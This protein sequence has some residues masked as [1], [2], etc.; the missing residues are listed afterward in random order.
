MKLTEALFRIANE[1]LKDPELSKD[2][3]EAQTKTEQA[4]EF[5]GFWIE[6]LKLP[7]LDKELDPY[8][9]NTQDEAA[10]STLLEAVT[11]YEKIPELRADKIRYKLR[12]EKVEAELEKVK[13]DVKQSKTSQDGLRALLDAAEEILVIKQKQVEEA[14]AELARWKPL[15]EWA[16][17]ADDSLLAHITTARRKDKCQTCDKAKNSIIKLADILS[18]KEQHET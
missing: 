1:G 2:T 8:V 15:I 9:W 17:K 10:L 18:D 13:A 5:L 11:D 3:S 12:A 14:R 4:L 16:E 6:F 7:G